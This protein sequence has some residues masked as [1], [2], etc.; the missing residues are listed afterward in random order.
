MLPTSF[1]FVFRG[2][3][4]RRERRSRGQFRHRNI[5][6]IDRS[7]D[8]QISPEIRQPHVDAGVCFDLGD[9]ARIHHSVTS[10][11]ASQYCHRHGNIVR[12]QAIVYPNQI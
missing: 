8:S 3:V 1:R 7:A 2:L 10:R 6:T 5:R 4:L 9:I 11:V 12:V